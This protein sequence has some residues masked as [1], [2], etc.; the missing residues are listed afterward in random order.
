MS[1]KVIKPSG[2]L[3]REEVWLLTLLAVTPETIKFSDSVKVA[4]SYL[5][6][7]DKRFPKEKADAQD[8]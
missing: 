4:D 6:E 2:N 8:H 3:S 5:E 7:F 1:K